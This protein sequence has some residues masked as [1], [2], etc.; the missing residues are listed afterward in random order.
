MYVAMKDLNKKID[1]E[2]SKAKGKSEMPDAILPIH[3]F[4][5][6]IQDFVLAYNKD[7]RLSKDF[8]LGSILSATSVAIGNAKRAYFSR[9]KIASASL[10]LAIVGRAG[11]NKSQPISIALKPVRRMEHDLDDE[12]QFIISDYTQEALAA[13]L[14][15]NKR[16]IIIVRDEL[17]GLINDFGRYNKGSGEQDLLTSFSGQSLKIN[18]KTGKPIKINLPFIAITGSIQPDLLHDL[19]KGRRKANGFLDRFL[20]V[21]PTNVKKE[22]WTNNDVSQDFETKYHSIIEK[23]L[24]L[25]YFED[26]DNNTEYVFFS[27]V[28]K[29]LIL[30]W[31]KGNTDLCNR[32]TDRMTSIYSKLEIYIL[33]FAL[34]LQCLYWAC[35]ETHDFEISER[36]AKGAIDLVEYFRT[37]AQNVA[38]IIDNSTALDNLD[39]EKRKLYDTLPSEFTK[40]TG[41]DI[42]GESMSD[43]SFANFLNSGIEMGLFEKKSHGIYM[44]K[45]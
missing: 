25:S 7:L 10:F 17:I 33:R 9:D 6:I 20:F 30:D 38:Y 3:I 36:A 44:K 12:K 28:A 45:Y 22:P 18:R 35:D 16:G 13:V 29:Q 2:R 19:A 26:E 5:K 41:L 39:I 42:K 37:T 34:I 43:R 15:K 32:S 27:Q 24:A 21:F 23:L 31:Q 40:Q 4:P 11:A 14:D 1:Q 8:L